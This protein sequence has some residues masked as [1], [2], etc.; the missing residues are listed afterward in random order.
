MATYNK[1]RMDLSKGSSFNYQGV[2][3]MNW[4]ILIP[5]FILPLLIYAPF[6]I[7]GYR[8]TGLAAI[9]VLGIIGML[10]RRFW[11]KMIEKGFYTRKYVMAEG[12]REGS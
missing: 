5:A 10:T 1:K 9:G 3:M 12:F 7:L 6:G 11:V 2:G 4:L 8:Y